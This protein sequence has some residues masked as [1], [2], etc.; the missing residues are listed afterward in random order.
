MVGAVAEKYASPFAGQVEGATVAPSI[1][2]ST[3]AATAGWNGLAPA[4]VSAVMGPGPKTS[5]QETEGDIEGDEAAVDEA[6]TKKAKTD[7]RLRI[8]GVD[9]DEGH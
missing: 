3:S 5:M 6:A 7:A 2:T 8:L 4:E 1:Q 9:P